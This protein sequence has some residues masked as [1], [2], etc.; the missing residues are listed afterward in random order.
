L[1]C[2]YIAQRALQA[3]GNHPVRHLGRTVMTA[4]RSDEGVALQRQQACLLKRARTVAVRGSPR[5]SAIS[6]NDSPTP[7]I[8]Q[9]LPSSITSTPK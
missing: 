5:S 7:S 4:D 1:A 9:G 2:F 6:P 3:I 8:R